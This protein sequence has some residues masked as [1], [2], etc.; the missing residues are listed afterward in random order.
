[1]LVQVMRIERVRL[2]GLVPKTL[3]RDRFPGY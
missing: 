2:A 1:M 3:H